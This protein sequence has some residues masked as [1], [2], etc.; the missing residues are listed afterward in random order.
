MPTPFGTGTDRSVYS[1]AA[2][3]HDG[4]GR[5]DILIADHGAAPTVYRNVFENG[6]Y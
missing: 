6:H 4:D 3:D 1:M 2:A 5:V